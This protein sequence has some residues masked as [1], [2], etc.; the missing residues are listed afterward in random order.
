MYIKSFVQS[1]VQH[2][3]VITVLLTAVC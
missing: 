3:F 2:S 1:I